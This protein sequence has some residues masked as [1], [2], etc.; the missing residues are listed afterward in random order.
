MYT[1]GYNTVVLFKLLPQNYIEQVENET[2]FDLEKRLIDTKNRLVFLVGL[3]AHFFKWTWIYFENILKLKYKTAFLHRSVHLF[4]C[5][6]CI[7]NC[8]ITN[9]FFVKSS[10]IMMYW[11]MLIGNT[12]LHVLLMISWEK[13]SYL[14]TPFR[15]A[16]TFRRFYKASLDYM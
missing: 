14:I 7:I 5:Q 8:I 15:Q 4:I 2:I 1:Q 13:S 3:H 9:N 16:Y 6:N 12:K 11:C 10:T